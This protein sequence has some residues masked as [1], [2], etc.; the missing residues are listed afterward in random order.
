LFLLA[1]PAAGAHKLEPISTEYALPFAP[2]TG[3]VQVLYEFERE[4]PGASEMAIPE[5]ELEL[6]LFPRFQVNVGFPLLRLHEGPGESRQVGGGHLEVGGRYLLFG[7]A[8]RSYAVS[9]Q[10]SVEAPTGSSAL[11]GDATEVGAAIHVDRTIGQR[12][13]LHSNLGWATSIGGEERPERVFRYSNAMVWVASL[14]WSPVVEVLGE[15]E[16]RTGDTKLAI[17]PEMIFWANRHL[18]LKMGVP[19]GLTA[20][21]PDVGVRAQVFVTW[22]A[23]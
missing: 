4:G 8:T 11:V 17:Q 9:L 14:H 7:G 22:G 20:N 3:A 19:I 5:T 6:G 16:T 18:E 21:T 1:A 2:W 12:V 15:T 10:G 23:E 13:R